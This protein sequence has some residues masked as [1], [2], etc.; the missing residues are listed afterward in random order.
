M[1]ATPVATSCVRPLKEPTIAFANSVLFGFSR[2]VPSRITTVSAPTTSDGGRPR[3]VLSRSYTSNALRFAF[4]ATYSDG[5]NSDLSRSSGKVEATT[6]Q[7]SPRMPFRISTRRGEDEASTMA[8]ART[9][10]AGLFSGSSRPTKATV[11]ALAGAGAGA[12]ALPVLVL[13]LAPLCRL[14]RRTSTPGATRWHG[15]AAA[16]TVS[17]LHTKRE[18]DK[19]TFLIPLQWVGATALLA[20]RSKEQVDE[21]LALMNMNP[22]WVIRIEGHTDNRGDTMSLMQLSGERA[23]A[24]SQILIA[25]GVPSERVTVDGIGPA[26]PL[27]TNRTESGRAANNR[28]EVY[29]TEGL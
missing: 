12:G 15:R 10:S 29:V 21:L 26:N 3:S 1:S 19:V 28:I 25:G 24:I 22:R 17:W 6:V 4:S 2:M 8:A 23:L 11:S 5:V 14:Q 13:V 20:D 7:P 27:T 16:R 9:K 18:G